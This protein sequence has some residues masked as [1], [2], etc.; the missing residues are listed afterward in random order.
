MTISTADALSLKEGVY[1]G[2]S[3]RGHT[4]T[5][6]LREAPDNKESFNAVLAQYLYPVFNDEVA[7]AVP[8]MYAFRIDRSTDVNAYIMRPLI[9]DNQNEIIVNS[10]AKASSLKITID[11]KGKLVPIIMLQ[12]N[13]KK[14][15]KI[16]LNRKPHS[17]WEDYVYGVY[18]EGNVL[19]YF[20]DTETAL[21]LPKSSTISDVEETA[22]FKNKKTTGEYKIRESQNAPGM[23]VFTKENENVQGADRV[24]KKIG[25]FI[26]IVNW[27]HKKE[28]KTTDELLLINPSK[29]KDVIIY[30][31]KEKRIHLLEKI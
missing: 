8:R 23:F 5:L 27:K 24:E 31:E 14:A 16:T 2:R 10:E 11:K 7:F 1:R 19:D 6:L 28:P 13:M 22:I 9:V 4:L 21:L 15:E 18:T 3:S 30:Y 25:V 29:P 26:D 12:R 20:F 17:T